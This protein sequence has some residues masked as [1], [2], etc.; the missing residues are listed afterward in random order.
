MTIKIT[1]TTDEIAAIIQTFGAPLPVLEEPEQN[2][3][4]WEDEYDD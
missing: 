4:N 3:E 1:G 2:D